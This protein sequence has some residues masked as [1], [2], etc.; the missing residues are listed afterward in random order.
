[1]SSSTRD[2][3]PLPRLR[4][5]GGLLVDPDLLSA[6][7]LTPT[8]AASVP[9]VSHLDQ[10]VVGD[11]QGREGAC[12][13][14]A[15][16]SW[17]EVHLR[18]YI[19]NRDCHTIYREALERAG[20]STGGLYF[21]EAF[22]AVKRAGWL[23][24]ASALHEATLQDLVSQPL[25]AGY[26]MTQAFDNVA[27]WGCL[28]HSNPMKG[29]RGYHAVCVVASGPVGHPPEPYVWIENSWGLSWGWNGIGFMNLNL[30]QKL[31][32]QLF[33]VEMP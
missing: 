26:I 15:F 19:S 11:D 33:K 4:P 17:C 9:M 20:R 12:A 6:A 23:P 10:C 25:I 14:F 29:E 28:D 8:L 5:L 13:I 21:H 24:W 1:M 18:A 2:P 27:P 31:C 7:P 32:R 3:L 30:H 22:E 16:A